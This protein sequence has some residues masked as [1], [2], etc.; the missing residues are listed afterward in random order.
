MGVYSEP[1]GGNKCDC[2]C[3][4]SSCTIIPASR[5]IIDGLEPG[6]TAISNS[7][8]FAQSFSLSAL[9]FSLHPAVEVTSEQGD[10]LHGQLSANDEGT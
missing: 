8:P 6:K 1:E 9:C 5:Q 3:V 10:V 4:F 2:H 7:I